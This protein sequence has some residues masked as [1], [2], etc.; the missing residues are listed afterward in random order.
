[1]ADFAKKIQSKYSEKN[2]YSNFGSSLRKVVIEGFRGIS[3]LELNLDYP[4]TVISG[5]NGLAKHIRPTCYLRI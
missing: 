2:R 4:I 3:S 5:L 1:M